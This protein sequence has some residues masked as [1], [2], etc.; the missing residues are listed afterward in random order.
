MRFKRLT[1]LTLAA[2]MAV[3]I[4]ACS[5]GGDSKNNDDTKQAPP[6]TT[7]Q[8]SGRESTNNAQEGTLDHS[9][10]LTLNVFSTTANYAGE[11]TGWY[12]KILKDKFNIKLNIIASNLDGGQ[13]KIAAMMASGDLG[14][15]V[16][17][18]S[19]KT[20]YPNAIKGGLLMD[21][22]QNGLLD[23]YGKTIVDNYPKVLEKAKIAFGDGKAV[24]GLGNK[25]ATD[26]PGPSEGKDLTWG[27]ELRWDL[28]QKIGAPEINTPQDY[29]PV[30][31]KMQELE[32][33]TENGKKTYA[34]SLWAD[35]DGN[36]KM[37]LAKQ[38]AN[39]YGYDENGATLLYVAADE[40]KYYEFLSDESWY[41]KSLKLYYDANQMGLLDPDSMTQKFD[42]VVG[43][44]KDGRI[45]FS[46][47]PWLG[48]ANYNT[49]ERSAEGKGLAT[50]PF[51][52]EK[53]YSWGFN[54]YGGDWI[55]AIGAKAKQPERIMEFI[56]WLYT[57]EGAMLS[58]G[59]GTAIANG[60]KGLT[61]D[62]GADGK[63][64]VTD[65][66]WKAYADQKGTDIP[67]EYGGGNFYY[68][69]S[70]IN[71]S[72]VA[73]GI[74]NPETGEPYDHNL[75]TTSLER[76]P[77]KL[78]QEWRDKMEALTP[79][80][81]FVKNNMIAVAPQGFTGKPP[82]MMD[83]ALEQKN[84]QIGTVIQQY[85]WR[86]IFAKDEGQYNKYKQEM[87]DKVKGLGYDEVLAFSVQKA[88]ELFEARKS[89][90]K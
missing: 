10:E 26:Q 18:G 49:Q 34:F 3:S 88:E 40:D 36:Y 77:S 37:T 23:K 70:Q 7:E 45:L 1:G 14:D 46:W 83:K 2:F 65:F 33:K 73:P 64:F 38:F 39:M 17:F 63:P 30:L 86:M 66:G 48:S 4:T 35:W 71:Y 79:K 62:I 69:Q 58:A 81:Y 68:G 89:V 21:M 59:D 15:I 57:P 8:T 55:M 12:G 82:I 43:K 22:T 87:L 28:Y 54:Q 24:Y 16:I 78:D 56:N 6:A 31:K 85:S 84:A 42:D 19:D 27:P 75:W 80:E 20:D 72:N 41:M 90:Q 76:N 32:P 29:L 50:V 11:Q 13:N 52:E 74:T 53:V 51:K 25:V 61:W 47:F 5:S 60:P 44:Y 67:A 9:K